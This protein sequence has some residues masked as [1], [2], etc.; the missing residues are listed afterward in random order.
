MLRFEPE[1][2]RFTRVR[3]SGL[4]SEAILERYDLQRGIVDSWEAFRNELGFPSAFLVGEEIRPH[5][6]TNDSLDL[7]AFDPDDSSLLLIELKRDRNKLQ[8]LQALSYAAML[9]TW[10]TDKLISVV[11]EKASPEQEEL[12]ELLQST[13]LNEHVKVIL[14]AEAF[15]P[16]VIIT[17]DWLH[18]RYGV[19]VTAFALSLHSV[20]EDYFVHL[21]QR[22]PLRELEEAYDIRGGRTRR[23]RPERPTE[24]GWADVIPS[25]EYPF[26][27][28]A[29]KLCTRIKPGDPARRRFGRFPVNRDG[30]SW[31][32]L[33]FR[34]KYINIYLGGDLDGIE[35]RLQSKFRDP[36]EI[37]SWRDGYSFK[38]ET[39]SHFDDLVKWLRFD[40][41]SGG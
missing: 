26:A 21:D 13:E 12:I 17:A 31:V 1:A 10:D 25:L 16:E 14:V 23:S 4:K 11:R 32:A 2:R 35:E 5:P 30:I 19:H 15:D 9:A 6:S 22:Y 37:L 20:G 18:R 29:V 38:I 3:D 24:L 40:E 34:K 39:Q 7:L 27:E 28:E 8:L 36:I 33:N 41:L